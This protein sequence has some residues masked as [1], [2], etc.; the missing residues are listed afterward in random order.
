[1]KTWIA[2]TLLLAGSAQAQTIWRCGPPEAPRYADSACADGRPMQV[3][4]ARSGAELQAA[5]AVAA[6]ERAL[7]DRMVEDRLLREAALRPVTSAAR[8][9]ALP[10]QI[11]VAG[12]AAPKRPPKPF[13]VKLPKTPGG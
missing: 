6:R 12:A 9:T 5:R 1:M 11:R 13:T 10:V 8:R 4:D 2:V 3:A 7:A